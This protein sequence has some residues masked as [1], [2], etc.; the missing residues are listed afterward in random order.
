[1][2]QWFL[3]L[4]LL[5]DT[6]LT[7]QVHPFPTQAACEAVSR[8]LTVGYEV[9]RKERLGSSKIAFSRCVSESDR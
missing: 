9:V 6:G 8:T 3:V 4:I 5:N 7:T 1:M 2:T